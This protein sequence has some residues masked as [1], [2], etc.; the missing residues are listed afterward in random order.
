MECPHQTAEVEDEELL[1]LCDGP[2]PPHQD[3]GAGVAR[4]ARAV[5]APV[6]RRGEDDARVRPLRNRR[7]LGPAP[8]CAG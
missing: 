1:P 6:L 5:P 4:L 8:G 2:V 7:G 3:L